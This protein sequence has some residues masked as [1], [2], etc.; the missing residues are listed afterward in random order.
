MNTLTKI[1]VNRYYITN[2]GFFLLIFYFFFGIVPGEQLPGYHY[3]L[4]TGFTQ[5]VDFLTLV[6][7]IWACYNLKC[8][9]FILKVLSARDGA[10]LYSTVGLLDG[11]RKWRT[12]LQLQLGIY[13]PVL[14]YSLIALAIAVLHHHLLSAIIIGLFDVGMLVLPLYIYN[15]KV[16][17]PGTLS[18]LNRLQQWMNQRV[19]KP[20]WLFYIYELLNNNIR[21]LVIVKVSSAV[22]LIATCSYMGN[23]YD[24]RMVLLGLLLVLLIH[25]VTVFQHRRFEDLYLGM[26][27]QLP[28]PLWKRFSQYVLTYGL[29]LLPEFILLL[30]KTNAQHLPLFIAYSLS[31]LLLLRSLLYF[32]SLDQDKYFRWVLLIFA[33]LLF[34]TLGHC[35]WQALAVTWAAAYGIF[36][37]RYYR[38]EAPLEEIE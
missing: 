31:A 15:R 7:F 22:V 29:L 13:A 21:S 26:V 11:P 34:L 27:V 9:S 30:V 3:A 10:F 35:Y 36:A 28:M 38:Y 8:I 23:T 17:R 18:F 37:L 32:P 1:F 14:I 6:L 20:L 4:I 24:E 12:W 16:Q 2:T 33:A 5:N 25:S 19:R